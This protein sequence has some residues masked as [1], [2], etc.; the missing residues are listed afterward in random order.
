M[1]KF[2]TRIYIVLL[3][4][5]SYVY[6]E[7]KSPSLPGTNF[8]FFFSVSDSSSSVD[9][10]S[11]PLIKVFS[12]AVF[13]DKLIYFPTPDLKTFGA[14]SASNLSCLSFSSFSFSAFA[15]CISSLLSFLSCSSAC[16]YGSKKTLQSSMIMSFS[17]LSFCLFQLFLLHPTR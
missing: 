7:L 8:A 6:Q 13:G 5:Y 16:S 14:D 15:C 9:R 4:S 11:L 2:I 1:Y 3:L 17:G 10:F 12:F